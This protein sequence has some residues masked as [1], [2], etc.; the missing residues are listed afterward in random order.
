[1]LQQRLEGIAASFDER[2]LTIGETHFTINKLL[3]MD[4]FRV[5]EKIRVAV[6]K[7]I[8]SVE[9]GDTPAT[10]IVSVLLSLPEETIA[11]IKTILFGAVTFTNRNAQTPRGLARDEAMA[12]VGLE[13]I[14]VYEVLAR[15]LAV[16]F[17]QSFVEITSRMA[18]IAPDSPSQNIGT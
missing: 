18:A 16:N 3:P 2:E 10:A 12:F 17:T 11:Q 1:M 7:S 14:H 8:R 13:P 6:G 15:C 4:G 5:M 9:T